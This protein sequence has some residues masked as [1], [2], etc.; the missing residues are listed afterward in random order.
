[1]RIINGKDL[2]YMPNGTVFSDINDKYFDPNGD[3]G[4]IVING[5]SI[6]CGHNESDDFW[7]TESGHFNGVLHMLDYVTCHETETET[8]H[9]DVKE[10][11]NSIM[12]TGSI[13]YDENDWL[14]VY[15]PD[16]VMCIIRNLIWTLS[17]CE[18]MNF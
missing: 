12:D 4:D 16:E 14:V 18:S 11:W 13:D 9:Y 7:S 10:E 3:N 6:I 2:G 15:N 1:M 8:E 5:L 17:G